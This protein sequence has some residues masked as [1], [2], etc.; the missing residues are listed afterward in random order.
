GIDAYKKVL[1]ENPEDLQS[2]YQIAENYYAISQPDLSTNYCDSLLTINDCH[3][4][5]L[6]LKGV[7]QMNEGQVNTAIN[8][9]TMAI[10]C[11]NY[12]IDAY[13][14]RSLMYLKQ[15]RNKE[16]LGDA[17]KAI[18][19]DDKSGLAYLIRAQIKTNLDDASA[20]KDLDQSIALGMS[21]S[22]EQRKL[23]CK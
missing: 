20:C 16:A 1:R 12:Y 6:N 9:F 13:I 15:G 8:Y 11:S 14:N 17:D 10:N 23:I 22:E 7:I 5:G 3:L 21:V 19:I 2:L 18:S 4:K